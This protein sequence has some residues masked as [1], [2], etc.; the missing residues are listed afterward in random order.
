MCTTTTILTYFY[1]T[2]VIYPLTKYL[3]FHHSS[4]GNVVLILLLFIVLY[5]IFDSWIYLSLWLKL[6]WNE[7]CL[8][9][10]FDHNPIHTVHLSEHAGK[11]NCKKTHLL[12]SSYQSRLKTH[13]VVTHC[14]DSSVYKPISTNNNTTFIVIKLWLQPHRA[15]K[16]Q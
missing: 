13:Q 10:P 7:K 3:Y 12:V 6:S 2:W 4:E 16:I 1:S 14:A 5:R 9:T 11:E 8:L 15:K